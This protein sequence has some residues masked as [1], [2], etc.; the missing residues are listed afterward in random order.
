MFDRSLRVSGV[1][2]PGQDVS[3]LG[4]PRRIRLVLLLFIGYLQ[5]Y[6]VM[7]ANVNTI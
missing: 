6:S 2:R 4:R 7:I 3:L 5:I 1:G